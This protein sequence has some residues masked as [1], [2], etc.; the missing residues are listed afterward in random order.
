MKNSSIAI[1]PPKNNKNVV[2]YL[3]FSFYLSFFF[4]NIF[5]I[6]IFNL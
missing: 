2:F 4:C 3:P 1:S 6:N 5:V